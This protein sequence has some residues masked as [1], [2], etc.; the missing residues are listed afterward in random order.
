MLDYVP[1]L[2]KKPFHLTG[3]VQ[4]PQR[5]AVGAGHDKTDDLLVGNNAI[6]IYGSDLNFYGMNTIV[7]CVYDYLY[8]VTGGYPSRAAAAAIVLFAIIMS[9]TIV[10]LFIS[11]KK[12][13]Y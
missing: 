7:G 12:V 5:S 9:I 4:C 1:S 2:G 13:H 6:G 10:N 3:S 8:S 11:K